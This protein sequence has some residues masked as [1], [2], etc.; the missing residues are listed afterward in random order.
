MIYIY[1]RIYVS[2]LQAPVYCSER[3]NLQ[4]QIWGTLC[5]DKHIL[6]GCACQDC[7]WAKSI[8]HPSYRLDTTS[9]NVYTIRQIK[10]PEGEQKCA[11]NIQHDWLVVWNMFYFPQ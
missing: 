11:F 3:V 9:D 5:S 4:Q 7:W 2:M 1:I 10:Q 6:L 8:L